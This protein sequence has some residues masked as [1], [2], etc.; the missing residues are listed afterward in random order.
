MTFRYS[1]I[2]SAAALVSCQQNSSPGART[3]KNKGNRPTI[4]AVNYP[5]KYFAERIAGDA[6]TIVLPAPADVDPAYWK[7]T[8]DVVTAIQ[9]ADLILLNGASY[10]K[11][12]Q[13]ASLPTSK[14]V[15]T[16][17][18]FQDRY[19]NDPQAVHHSHGPGGEH[20]HSDVAITTWLDPELALL[21][22]ESVYDALGKLM[23]NHQ[24][25]LQT[26]FETLQSDLRGLV[27]SLDKMNA[28]VGPRP[29]LASHPVYQYLARRCE[30][31]LR[32]LHWEP[33]VYPTEDQWAEL[34]K[35]LKERAAQWMIWE[36]APLAKTRQRLQDLKVN[37]IEFVPC[38]N[39][40]STGDYLKVMKRNIDNL[41]AVAGEA[42]K[43]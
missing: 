23:P 21:Q 34:D 41:G 5:L 18:S 16:S 3:E 11:W 1:L 4:Y 31:D 8:V 40:P 37:V 14:T 7:P 15:N 6:A 39:V 30:W 17:A 36:Q 10:A 33:D 26:N 25:S 19:I 38:G 22:A 28:G 12:T 43:N 20:V 9:Q 13:S 42:T 35:L 2:L 32:S 29:L 27:A 24:L